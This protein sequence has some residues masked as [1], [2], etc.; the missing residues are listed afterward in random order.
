MSFVAVPVGEREP[1]TKVTVNGYWKE[2][3]AH[4]VPP[5]ATPALQSKPNKFLGAKPG[6]IF[7]NHDKPAIFHPLKAPAM[8]RGTAEQQPRLPA[9]GS[10]QEC[11]SSSV[12]KANKMT[13]KS[14][15]QFGK[16][17]AQGRAPKDPRSL[18]REPTFPRPPAPG[19]S[20]CSETPHPEKADCVGTKL[21]MTSQLCGQGR[22]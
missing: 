1:P 11:N 18:A 13:Q 12:I 4:R 10:R 8:P 22:S 14:R 9:K 21:T 15:E 7:H 6:K 16:G 19:R 20:F 17:K 3:R 5:L 2:E